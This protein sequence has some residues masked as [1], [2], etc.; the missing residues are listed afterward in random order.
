MNIDLLMSVRAYEVQ[1]A[2]LGDGR[3]FDFSIESRSLPTLVGSIFKGKIKR[4]LPG[5]QAAFVDIGLERTAFLHVSDLI[6]PAS[7]LPGDFQRD[8]AEVIEAFIEEQKQKQPV[9]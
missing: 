2:I 9:L 3:L 8:E 1:V 7:K 6:I 4:I 5:M